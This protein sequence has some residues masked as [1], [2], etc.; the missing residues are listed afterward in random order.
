MNNKTTKLVL[1]A[2]FTALTCIA[3][4][5]IQIPTIGTSGYVNIGDTMVLVSAWILGAP[6]G[7][8]AAGIGSGLADLLAGYALYV[9]GTT[10]IKAL[11]ALVAFIIFT[12]LKNTKLPKVVV[13]VLS[14]I[15]AEIV[16]V[17]GYF[18]YESTL[19]GYGPAA[20]TSIP[21]NA[22]QGVTCLVLGA[23]LMTV[24]STVRFIKENRI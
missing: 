13:Y 8:L 22:I 1:T 7:I 9:P 10:I 14:S 11:M 20:A 21:S 16:M 23:V 5:V 3:T 24:L 4:M 12:G 15:P 17:L 19:L 6:Y 18:L 2:M